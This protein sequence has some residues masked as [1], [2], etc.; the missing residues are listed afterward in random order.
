MLNC[1]PLNSIVDIFLKFVVYF[2]R[3]I[4]EHNNIYNTGDFMIL[5]E[6]AQS[7]WTTK[8]PGKEV[9]DR[10]LFRNI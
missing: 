9:I 5:Q 6:H 8:E 7:Q 4:K 3:V 2:Y 10:G 1:L